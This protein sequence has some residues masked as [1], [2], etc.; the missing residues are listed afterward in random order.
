MSKSNKLKPDSMQKSVSDY[1][2]D[3]AEANSDCEYST[4]IAQPFWVILLL[5]TPYL[6][7]QEPSRCVVLIIAPSGPSWD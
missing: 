6:R 2:V 7:G 1:L 5:L 3:Q 4:P